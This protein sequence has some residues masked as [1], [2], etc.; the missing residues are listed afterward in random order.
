MHRL[1]RG[2]ARSR[3]RRGLQCRRP[4]ARTWNHQGIGLHDKPELRPATSPQ[5]HG[6]DLPIS[7]LSGGNAHGVGEPGRARGHLDPSKLQRSGGS[8]GRADRRQIVSGNRDV[9]PSS[10]QTD[11]KTERRKGAG[12]VDGSAHRHLAPSLV[13]PSAM[14]GAGDLGPGKPSRRDGQGEPSQP[15]SPTP[16]ATHDRQHSHAITERALATRREAR[17]AHFP[18]DGIDG[19]Q[20]RPHPTDSL[21]HCQF[22]RSRP[23]ALPQTPHALGEHLAGPYPPRQNPSELT[24]DAFESTSAAHWF[25]LTPRASAIIA[26]WAWTSG[27]SRS[28][29]LPEYG[30]RGARPSF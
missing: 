27:G 22:Q 2:W 10:R 24:H 19:T 18:Q 6:L 12:V 7:R 28:I 16:C 3:E 9:A 25:R 14:T 20:R 4:K 15:D 21:P 26:A 5:G 17:V 11:L 8:S 23:N 30:F 13:R 1:Y 29:R